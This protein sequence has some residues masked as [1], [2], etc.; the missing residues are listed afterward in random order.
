MK[1]PIP[2][3]L[4]AMAD[5]AAAQ[6]NVWALARV[7]YAAVLS[8]LDECRRKCPGIGGDI[9][10]ANLRHMIEKGITDDRAFN[11]AVDTLERLSRSLDVDA[12]HAIVAAR[13]LPRVNR[14]CNAHHELE[15]FMHTKNDKGV[16]D[17]PA[18][19]YTTETECAA[20]ACGYVA[21]MN[22]VRVA[23]AQAAGREGRPA[24]NQP[25][26]A[27]T[28]GAGTQTSTPFDSVTLKIWVAFGP[29]WL[30]SQRVQDIAEKCGAD[31]CGG[32]GDQGQ[33]FY[34]IKMPLWL[35]FKEALAAEGFI[36]R[37]ST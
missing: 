12:T 30:L 2:N 27:P 4:D 8:K 17:A 28:A 16:N 15:V 20:W 3:Q 33:L 6:L 24:V 1:D 25:T 13:S 34:H 35:K 36:G 37:I 32:A 10:A 22:A 7:V 18:F 14:V 9:D 19:L 11:Q 5:A 29:D 31:L 21:A 23:L 26:N